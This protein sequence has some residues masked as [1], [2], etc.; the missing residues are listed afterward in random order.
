MCVCEETKMIDNRAPETT[1]VKSRSVYDIKRE[2]F[3]SYCLISKI[4]HH[5]LIQH[6]AMNAMIADDNYQLNEV[7]Q[8]HEMSLKTVR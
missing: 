5:Q 4:D 1:S 6:L 7:I 3:R 2:Y 8:V